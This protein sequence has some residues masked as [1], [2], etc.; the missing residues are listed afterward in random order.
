MPNKFDQMLLK[1][2]EAAQQAYLTLLTD[3]GATEKQAFGRSW[4]KAD[5]DQLYDQI[6]KLEKRCEARGLLA[7]NL[8][9]S[10]LGVVQLQEWD[11][12]GYMR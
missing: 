5:A 12:R 6:T 10:K 11:V 3:D 7:V 8:R 4:K 9:S 2:L 1:S